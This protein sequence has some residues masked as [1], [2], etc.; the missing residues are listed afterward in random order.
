MESFDRR[1]GQCL[2]ANDLGFKGVARLIT[3][4]RLGPESIFRLFA[5]AAGEASTKAGAIV[6]LSGVT[7]AY[8]L[9][10][11]NCSNS[12]FVRDLAMILLDGGS[13]DQANKA[14]VKI[15][16]DIGPKQVDTDVDLD[17]DSFAKLDD[18]TELGCP[19]W[20]DTHRLDNV[21]SWLGDAIP[22]FLD[23]LNVGVGQRPTSFQADCR[24]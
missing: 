4:E 3:E 6:L 7:A 13:F 14:A 17:E 2:R 22:E 21:Q 20:A 9:D 5:V 10:R 11:E 15:V 16:H 8:N 18:G 24:W 1:F 19:H 23:A 12:D